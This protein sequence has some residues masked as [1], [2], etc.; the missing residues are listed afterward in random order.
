VEDELYN[1]LA[2]AGAQFFAILYPVVPVHCNQP[3]IVD[4][5]LCI[6]ETDSDNDK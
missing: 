4:C 5:T 1:L 6:A 3:L 2:A